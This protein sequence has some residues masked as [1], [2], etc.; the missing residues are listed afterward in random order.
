MSLSREVVRPFLC[1]CEDINSPRSL[2]AWLLLSNGEWD[3]LVNLKADPRQYTNPHDYF[4]DCL[5]TEMFRKCEDLPTTIDRKAVAV[6]NFWVAEKQCY[7]SNERLSPLLS[8]GLPPGCSEGVLPFIGRVRKKIADILGPCPESPMGRFGPGATYD[9]RGRFTTVPDK[10]SSDLT[11]TP[12]AMGFLLPWAGTAWATALADLG[13]APKFVRGNRFTTVPKD[14]TKDRGIAIEPSL[15]VFYQLAYG[16]AIRARLRSIG[17][18][19]QLG[20][21]LHRR[22]ARQ[23]SLN[24]SLTTIDLS[25]ASDTV[26]YNLVKLLLPE[27]WF[28][29]LESLR[30]PFTLLEGRWVRLEKF[31]SMGNGFTFELESLLFLALSW[32]A[33][34]DCGSSPVIGVDLSVYGDDIIIPSDSSK[35]VLA[36]LHFFGFTPN[37]RKTFSDGWFRES[38]GGDFF[39][40][41]PVRP[42]HVDKLPATPSEYI[43]WA[44]GIRRVI[45]EH[46]GDHRFCTYFP[47]MWHRILDAIP[48]NVKRLRGPELLGDLV[49]HDDPERWNLRVRNGIRYVRAWKTVNSKRVH[50][51]HF[52]SSVVYASALYGVGDGSNGS[53]RHTRNRDYGVIPRNAVLG[54]R[55]GWCVIP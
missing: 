49:I 26:S 20:Q 44:N 5:V 30:S 42:H 4:Q 45:Y 33:S 14:A 53:S 54:H 12:G 36:V 23:G 9:D 6:E 55:E 47:R 10:M 43:S 46:Y 16:R 50:W 31:S 17:V 28:Q 22:L 38:C 34:E 32:A 41:I 8:G 29:T 21:D 2:A 13:K 25:N 27:K 51:N 1:L 24:G 11:L 40:G 37:T 39:R 18:D 15:N 35:G 52:H 7:L 3:Q 19:L 48:F